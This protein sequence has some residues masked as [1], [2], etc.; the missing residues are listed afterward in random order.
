MS[1]RLAAVL[2]AALALAGCAANRDSGPV[3]VRVYGEPAAAV[4]AAAPGAAPA[5]P[6]GGAGTLFGRALAHQRVGVAFFDRGG[7]GEVLATAEGS[8]LAALRNAGAEVLDQPTLERL[9]A[10][11]TAYEVA[12]NPT[13]SQLRELR[14]RYQVEI[15]L[16]GFCSAESAQGVGLLWVGTANTDLRATL[17]E[18]AA[19]MGNATSRPFGTRSNP[20]PVADTA[21]AAKRLAIER[22]LADMVSL[23]G[24]GTVVVAAEQPVRLTYAEKLRRGDSATALAFSP[25]SRL[26]AVAETGAVSLWDV[27]RQSLLWRQSGGGQ[28]RALAFSADGARLVAGADDGRLLVLDVQRGQ[29]LAHLGN[30]EAVTALGLSPNG[31]HAAVGRQ[32]GEVAVWDLAGGQPLVEFSAH[33]G[34]V[35]MVSYTRDGRTVISAGVDQAVQFLDVYG[36]RALRSL[37]PVFRMGALHSAALS[38]C[39][40]LLALGL[41]EIRVYRHSDRVDT[42]FIRAVD[43][44]TGEEEQRFEAHGDPVTALAFGPTRDFLLSGS[45]DSQVKVWQPDRAR[46]LLTIAFGS[47]VNS[48][49]FSR[50]GRWLAAAGAAGLRLWEV[51]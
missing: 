13:I 23:A 7:C 9:R 39:G 37:A 15:L 16:S 27:E 43:V 28:V 40:R 1:V 34:R 35:Q 12:M 22:A 45:E 38:P 30:G 4:M 50:N 20:S 29:A 36:R 10:D 44:L 2:A 47:P 49:D 17:A 6:G 21:L 51:R 24:L 5:A 19:V 42:E 25:D 8:V 18:T 32:S 46:A 26:L 14:A 3:E 41:K 33:R 48:V 31:Q 11:R